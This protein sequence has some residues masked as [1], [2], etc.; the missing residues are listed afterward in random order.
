MRSIV[1]RYVRC[2]LNGDLYMKALECLKAIRQ[3][4]VKED[5]APTFNKFLGSIKDKFAIGPH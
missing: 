3:A 5:E 4:C 1:E 2:S